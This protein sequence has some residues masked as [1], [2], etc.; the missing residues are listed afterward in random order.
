MRLFAETPSAGAE[1]AFHAVHNGRNVSLRPLAPHTPPLNFRNVLLV[2][3][4]HNLGSVAQAQLQPGTGLTVISGETGAGKSLILDALSLLLGGRADRELVGPQGDA[5]TVAQNAT[6]GLAQLAQYARPLGISVLVENHGGYSSNGQWLADVVSRA[7]PGCG[8]LPDFGNF[9]IEHD[10][11]RNCITSYDRYQGLAELLPLAQAVSA[12]AKS[13]DADGNETETDFM[14]AMGLVQAA[15]YRGYIG[16][17]Y[18][19]EQL[20]GQ[21]EEKS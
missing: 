8:T 2:L 10:A 4:V 11:D 20:T 3:T 14:R 21:A 15:G 7:G 5:A 12:K 19:G 18:E 17:E 6:Q 9:C 13:F 16:I 1:G